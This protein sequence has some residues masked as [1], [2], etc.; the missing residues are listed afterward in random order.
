MTLAQIV[1]EIRRL[2]LAIELMGRKLE[3]AVTRLDAYDAFVRR[4]VRGR[5]ENG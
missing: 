3:A 2:D 4:P 5:K 1:I